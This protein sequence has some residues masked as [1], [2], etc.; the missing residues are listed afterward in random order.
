MPLAQW[1]LGAAAA[2]L[3]I[4]LASSANPAS[5]FS[6]AG[7]RLAAAAFNGPVTAQVTEVIDGDTFRASAQIWLG[8]AVDVHVR[9]E[10]I[11]APEL[12]AHCAEER[13]KAE[14]ARD[15]LIHRIGDAEV[16]LA[17]VR[18]DKYGG[19]V[20]AVVRDAGGDIAEAMIRQGL[21]RAYHGEK[22]QPWC[23]TPA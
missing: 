6:P 7:M 12:R 5:D 20:R 23:A 3:L 4:A 1:S 2:G 10:G 9:I 8:Q 13:V 18:Y 22:R 21:A 17:G 15:W 11:D 14:A 19:R 16:Q